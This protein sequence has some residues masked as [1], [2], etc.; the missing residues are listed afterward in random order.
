MTEQT[1]TTATKS[2]TLTRMVNSEWRL[3]FPDSETP[4]F[5]LEQ[6]IETELNELLGVTS[7]T[8]IDEQSFD[9]DL[10]GDSDDDERSPWGLVM[11]VLQGDELV[12]RAHSS[13]LSL[14][15]TP[16]I[17]SV[18]ELT[19]GA[20]IILWEEGGEG[21]SRDVLRLQ[22]IAASTTTA[23]P[24][25]APPPTTAATTTTTAAPTTTTTAVATTTTSAAATTT[26]TDAPTTTTTVAPTTT[27]TVAP[28]TTTT[29]APTTTT[30]DAPTT[31]TTVAPTTTTTA[32]STAATSTTCAPIIPSTTVCNTTNAQI[33]AAPTAATST[34]VCNQ[35]TNICCPPTI[36]NNT[37]DCS[38]YY[39]RQI[40]YRDQQIQIQQQQYQEQL[41]QHQLQ[42][43]RQEEQHQEQEAQ[44]KQYLQEYYQYL[45]DNC[46]S[47]N[48]EVPTVC[49]QPSTTVCEQP[50]TTVCGHPTTTAAATTTTVAPTT[51]T[52]TTVTPTTTTVPPTTQC[53][54]DGLLW[55]AKVA[56]MGCIEAWIDEVLS[57]PDPSI[58]I[59]GGEEEIVIW[60]LDYATEHD[61]WESSG[62]T[63]ITFTSSGVPG[64][65]S[66]GS[67]FSINFIPI[68]AGEEGHSLCR[69]ATVISITCVTQTTAPPTTTTTTTAAP[70]S[71]VTQ[72]L[73]TIGN[74][75]I[76]YNASTGKY[77]IT[78]YVTGGT[79]PY[80]YYWDDHQGNTRVTSTIYDLSPG[81]TWEVEVSDQNGAYTTKTFIL[82]IPTTTT[83]APTTTTTSPETTSPETTLPDTTLPDT[84]LPDTTLP[85]TTLPET[86]LTTT[87]IGIDIVIDDDGITHDLAGSLIAGLHENEP[88]LGGK[89]QHVNYFPHGSIIVLPVS[90]LDATNINFI[91]NSSSKSWYWQVD[92]GSG[93]EI[94]F[95]TVDTAFGGQRLPSSFI[96]G[97][98]II[99]RDV[100]QVNYSFLIFPCDSEDCAGIDVFIK[101]NKEV[102]VVVSYRDQE[103]SSSRLEIPDP[104]YPNEG[105]LYL[106]GAYLGAT[107]INFHNLTVES[108]NWQLNTAYGEST[109]YDEIPPFQYISWNFIKHKNDY[110]N[111]TDAF[112]SGDEISV[113]W[114]S[115]ES[116]RLI[117]TWPF[118]WP[119]IEVLLTDDGGYQLSY[120]GVFSD[121]DEPDTS[122]SLQSSTKTLPQKYLDA[123]SAQIKFK[124]DSDTTWSF[125]DSL[126]QSDD[127]WNQLL[128]GLSNTEWQ[129][130][131]LN[132]FPQTKIKIHRYDITTGSEPLV[133]TLRFEPQTTLPETT[134]PDT[135]LPET[136][137]APTTTPPTGI[138]ILVDAAGSYQW[139]FEDDEHYRPAMEPL[140]VHQLPTSSLAV[141]Q[142]NFTNNFIIPLNVNLHLGGEQLTIPDIA[143]QIFI[144]TADMG[145]A[146]FVGGDE[147]IITQ[148][149]EI[150]TPEPL[151]TLVFPHR[152]VDV[153]I[154]NNRVTASYGG[155]SVGAD[156]STTELTLP[157]AYLEATQINFKN[158]SSNPVSVGY[159][160]ASHGYLTLKNEL[161]K[162]KEYQWNFEAEHA[163]GLEETK[164]HLHPKDKIII[165]NGAGSDVRWY[166]E[167]KELNQ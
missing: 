130:F 51:T 126:D 40:Q 66:L 113:T 88:R 53:L 147:I 74:E 43:E 145:G 55:V 27:T 98:K 156:K 21:E 4:S 47:N 12:T 87:S 162:D 115:G 62:E 122:G 69:K 10:E 29:V 121:S 71:T 17:A 86:T 59:I 67:G 151:F 101:N 137:V 44:Y 97:D 167:F 114:G 15:S 48:V 103:V 163:K 109:T 165:L 90:Y 35:I 3:E 19:Q 24:L 72:G 9:H 6:G 31:T 102:D 144:T 94:P 22:A 110:I 33:T 134:L 79:A 45:Q 118:S 8:I 16:I 64:I 56:A 139:R 104:T 136:T 65:C 46:H 106:L 1:Q 125:A 164:T 127:P 36:V 58:N 123:G 124:N 76:I 149:V 38:Q 73:L 68:P 57:D 141:T 99:I 153:V 135:T 11:E 5:S 116:L 154:T 20:T 160:D 152:V 37:E 120:D 14:S 159:V 91:N 133:L 95:E 42:I 82:H 138:D 49:E 78:I 60:G 128:F 63:L 146:T 75:E 117:F 158:Q 105:I 7:I 131:D 148:R 32:A 41:R 50:P 119:S 34:T 39:Q 112:K 25:I 143:D 129:S 93:Q 80:L 157:P 70:E 111:I 108:R 140:T 161:E 28:T 81:D 155:K 18:Y 61:E 2:L 96:S 100:N 26:T 23:P 132:F 85:D 84:T 166:L 107:H 89:D 150:G 142:I 30:T 52:T 83:V 77:S 92:N 54:C 13:L